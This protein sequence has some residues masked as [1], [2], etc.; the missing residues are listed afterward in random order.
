MKKIYIALFASL[1]MFAACTDDD[2]EYGTSGKNYI[3]I[4][5]LDE[6]YDIVT[7][8]GEKLDI[9]PTVETSYADDDLEYTWTYYDESKAY[10]LYHDKE[11]GK[12]YYLQPDTISHD[13]N[14]DW[15]VTIADGNYNLT[16]TVKSKS[17]GLSQQQSTNVHVASTLS[18]GFY[19]LKEDAEGNTDVDMYNTISKD[20]TRDV[21][22]T[23]QGKA[24]PGKPRCMDVDYT[25]SYVNEKTGNPDGANMLCITTDDNEVRFIR[26]MDCTTVMD[27][28]NCHFEA[29]PGEIPYRAVRGYWIEYYVTSNGVYYSYSPARGTSGVLGALSG[30]GGSEHVVSMGQAGFY[31]IVYWENNSRSINTI[32]YNGSSA[33]VMSRVDGY[34]ARNLNYDCID[35]GLNETNGCVDYFLLQD[36]D[37]ASKKILYA[38]TPGMSGCYID[39]VRTVDPASHFANAQL[40]AFC[41]ANATIAYSVDNNKVYTYNLVSDS[42]EKELSFQGLPANEQITFIS[43]RRFTGNAAFDYLVIGTQSGNTYKLYFY[44]TIGGEPDGEPQLTLIGE[45]KLKTIGYIDPSVD[46]MSEQAALPILDE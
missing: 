12:D 8:S 21:I 17:T 32:D 31:G 18:R 19:I 13:R 34:G 43:N 25:M 28:S 33:Y 27:E 41:D 46:E 14:L 20:M 39:N 36:R 29:T 35:C 1:A 37:D 11:T 44:N 5:G 10:T 42:P 9:K 15:D 4:G 38:I 40:R 30:Y 24:I 3:N 26:A 7:F 6:S 2:S 45:G 16:L 22:R 23:F